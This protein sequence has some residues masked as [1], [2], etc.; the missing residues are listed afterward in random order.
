MISVAKT[1][2]M[3]A[4]VASILVMTILLSAC[5]EPVASPQKQEMEIVTSYMIEEVTV[6]VQQELPAGCEVYAGV[7]TLQYLGFG[8]YT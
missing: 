7:V 6:Y 2:R 5:K 3:S 1:R 4:L 8:K